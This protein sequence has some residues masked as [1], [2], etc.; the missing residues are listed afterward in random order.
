M[1]N[2]FWIDSMTR[3]ASEQ[4]GQN[5]QVAGRYWQNNASAHRGAPR[6]HP[7][8]RPAP[9][10]GMGLKTP[11]FWRVVVS[12]KHARAFARAR[13]TKCVSAYNTEIAKTYFLSQRPLRFRASRV[14]R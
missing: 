5:S 11:R 1:S 4:W 2:A 14:P 6:A 12:G 8:T 9:G 10:M 3:C 13:R 7:R